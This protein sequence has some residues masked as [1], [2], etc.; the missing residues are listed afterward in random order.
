VFE[1]LSE[2]TLVDGVLPSR[3]GVEIRRRCTSQPTEQ[4][5][6]LLQPLGL[7]LPVALEQAQM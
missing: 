3:Q 6:V 4:Q 2:I 5:R 7:S 1:E